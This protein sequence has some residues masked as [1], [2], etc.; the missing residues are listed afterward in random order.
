MAERALGR[1]L[2]L[3]LLAAGAAVT[4]ALWLLARAAR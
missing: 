1:L 4:A 3:A 2:L